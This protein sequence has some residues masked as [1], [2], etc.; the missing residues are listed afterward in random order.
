M[1]H[2]LTSPGQL[3][4]RIAKILIS[5]QQLKLGPHISFQ[6]IH[7]VPQDGGL[8]QN[9]LFLLRNKKRNV[10]GAAKILED[11]KQTRRNVC[12]SITLLSVHNFP[13]FPT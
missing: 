11:I 9:L 4:E 13:A 12:P 3:R 5:P 8:R 1:Q 6:A 2:F 10:G 7:L